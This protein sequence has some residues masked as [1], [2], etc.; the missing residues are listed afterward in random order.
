MGA[1]LQKFFGI[2]EVGEQLDAFT[3]VGGSSGAG[4]LMDHDVICNLHIGFISFFSKGDKWILEKVHAA[5]TAHSQ[6][7]VPVVEAGRTKTWQDAVTRAN[8]SKHLN[9]LVD[10]KQEKLLV[11]MG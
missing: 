3:D 6:T 1:W 5:Q 11:Q 4:T 8:I 2:F 10:M 7:L 9:S